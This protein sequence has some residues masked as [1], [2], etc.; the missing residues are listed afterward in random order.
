LV[1]VGLGL[2]IRLYLGWLG[3]RLARLGLG[4]SQCPRCLSEYNHDGRIDNAISS[5][6]S[7]IAVAI[8]GGYAQI[9]PQSI[10]DQP[11]PSP[12]QINNHH[13]LPHLRV[14][15]MLHAPCFTHKA[16]V[17]VYTLH[18]CNSVPAPTLYTLH[19]YPYTYTLYLHIHLALRTYLPHSVYLQFHI[20]CTYTCTV[21]AHTPAPAP[22]IPYSH[23]LQ[24]ALQFRT[25]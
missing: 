23:I 12:P 15:S 2:G 25:Y 13:S 20:P 14:C 21:P 5:V 11:P 24:S 4:L 16:L 10:I 3:L 19:L 6:S 22:V 7:T 1:R 18:S 9:K 17:K 8:P